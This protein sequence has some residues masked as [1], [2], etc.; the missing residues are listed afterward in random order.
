MF[1]FNLQSLK[2]LEAIPTKRE[3]MDEYI[4]DNTFSGVT[5]WSPYTKV[6][7]TGEPTKTALGNLPEGHARIIC[8]YN[9]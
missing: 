7:S 5:F 6:F 1:V 4:K 3:G 9:T 2:N 8:K